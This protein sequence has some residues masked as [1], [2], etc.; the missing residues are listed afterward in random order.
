MHGVHKQVAGIL[1]GVLVMLDGVLV[2]DFHVH[3]GLVEELG[4]LCFVV[5]VAAV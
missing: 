5:V 3:K 4:V 1:Q 2:E